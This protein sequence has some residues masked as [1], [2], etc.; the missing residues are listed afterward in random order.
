MVL[1]SV[2]ISF[3]F[4]FFLLAF[5]FLGP[6]SRHMEIPRLGVLPELQLLTYATATAMPDLSRICNLH[7]SS[8]QRQILNP[9]SKAR[10]Q[11]RNLMVP[12]RIRFCHAMAGAPNFI[13][14]H[15]AVQFSQHHLLKGLSFFHCIFLPSLS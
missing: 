3:L 10:D 9:L 15:T 7:H 13:L 11:T 1:G 12:S 4:F 8:Q 5:V 2:L 14:L 6:H